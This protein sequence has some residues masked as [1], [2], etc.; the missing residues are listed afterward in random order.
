[1][2]R[3]PTVIDI[4]L[5][6]TITCL[7]LAIALLN[8][9][10]DA[11]RTPFV[12]AI[13]NTTLSLV[14]TVQNV[15]KNK[16]DCIQLL[17]NVYQLLCVIINLHII[18]LMLTFMLP[19]T[20]SALL[21]LWLAGF[22]HGANRR[23]DTTIHMYLL[24]RLDTPLPTASIDRLPLATTLTPELFPSLSRLELEIMSFSTMLEGS[25]RV[26]VNEARMV[27][28]WLQERGIL[29]CVGKVDGRDLRL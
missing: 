19:I 26:I 17:E 18:S 21:P 22:L 3:Q 7:T 11:F 14:T 12:P 2:S 1:M 15:K 16:K 6:N 5:N 4:R 24:S 23:V 10:N 8:E 29:K 9:L 13:S 27:L 28:K 20:G 25:L